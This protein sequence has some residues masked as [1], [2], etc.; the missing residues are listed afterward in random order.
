[1]KNLKLILAGVLCVAIALSFSIVG[2]KTTAAETTA[3]ETTAA[4][5][6]AAETTAAETTAA[7]ATA[8]GSELDPKIAEVWARADQFRIPI[9]SDFKGPNGETVTL[10]KDSL[11]LTVDEVK[12]IQEGNYKIATS[13]NTLDG[14]YFMAWRQGA[15][16]CAKYLNLDI[17]AEASA[18]FDYTKQLSDIESFIPLK[19]DVIISAPIDPVGSAQAFRPALDAGIKLAFVSNIPEGYVKGKDYIGVTTSSAHDYGAFAYEM[20]YDLVGSGGKVASITW[21]TV[22]WY[23]VYY[24]KVFYDLM[25]KGDLNLVQEEGYV[26][27][28]DAY[29]AA[30]AIILK[31]PDIK[32]MWVD[33]ATP[34][35]GAINAI[36]DAGKINDIDIVTG[37]YDEPTLL[38]LVSGDVDGVNGDTT[39]LVGWDSVLLAAYG[40]LGKEGPDYAICPAI[41]LTLKNIRDAWAAGTGIPLPESVDKALKEKGF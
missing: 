35:Q 41:K 39:Y 34:G 17:V 29:K 23:T 36:K 30:N 8:S 21:N 1:M 14:E 37:P 33:Y 10:D 16:D 27:Y 40:I 24:Q 11:K 18:D 4:E 15:I 12:K 25:A 31:N 19:P 22:N 9:A 2:C 13:W 3:A 38:S 20:L 6:T 26:D 32:A 28:D 5:T 7:E